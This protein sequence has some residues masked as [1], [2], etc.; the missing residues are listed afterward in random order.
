MKNYSK[1]ML[2]VGTTL[3]LT[4]GQSADAALIA[5]WSFD[6]DFTADVGGASYDG[7]STN[8]ATIVAGGKSGSAASFDK[9]LNQYVAVA[10][11]PFTGADYSYTAWYRNE[12]DILADNGRYFVLETGTLWA[13]SYGLKVS[14]GAAVGNSYSHTT[15]GAGI[16]HLIDNGASTGAETGQWHNII[17]TFDSSTGEL[18]SYLDGIVAGSSTHTGT[19]TPTVSMNIGGHRAGE[20]RNF[21]GLIDEVG[22]YDH[23]LTS[24]EIAGI[25]PEPASGMLLALGGICLVG[26]RK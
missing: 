19:L 13:A 16:N 12:A 6:S 5:Q 1:L 8:G 14:G 9:S 25:V 23:V 3:A 20:G 21:H 10:A 24:E 11:S 4:A 18:T 15:G 7:T 17:V 2:A 22:V 26:R